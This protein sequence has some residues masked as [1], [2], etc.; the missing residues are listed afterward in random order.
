MFM[1][2]V[3]DI[4]ASKQTEETLKSNYALLQI[5][6]ETARFGGWSVDLETNIATWSDAV[7]DIHEVPHGYAPPAKEGINFYAP[8]WRE[9]ITQVFNDCARRGIPY[10][11]E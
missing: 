11:E 6:G 8:E 1:E 2:W 4:T 10:D 3:R 7:A 5:A 9:K